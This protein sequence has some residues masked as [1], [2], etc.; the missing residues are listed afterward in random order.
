MCIRDSSF[1]DSYIVPK[2]LI[3]L[4]VF[5]GFVLYCTIVIWFTSSIKVNMFLVG[6]VLI[7][8]C[9]LQAVLGLLQY[10]SLIH[11]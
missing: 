5:G 10:L 7:A 1:T 4:F 8:I 6:I 2:W 9:F 11:I 3:T